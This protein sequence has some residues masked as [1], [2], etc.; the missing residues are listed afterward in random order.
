MEKLLKKE[1]MGGGDIK[2]LFMT[3]LYFPWQLNV[4]ALIF[5]CVAGIGFAV[6]SR[7]RRGNPFPFGPAI[8]CGAWLSMLFGD[9]IIPLIL[10][11]SGFKSLLINP[12]AR[13]IRPYLK[14]AHQWEVSS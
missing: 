10:D 5:A 12:A 11:F 14:G 1:A 13:L 9:G 2:L 4:L 7:V 3:G 6:A 8:A